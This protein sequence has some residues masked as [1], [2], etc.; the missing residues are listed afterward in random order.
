M[1]SSSHHH[2]FERFYEGKNVSNV[3]LLQFVWTD[4]RAVKGVR[5]VVHLEVDL[6]EA[7][8]GKVQRSL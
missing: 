5:Q 6:G 4:G 1:V 7:V 2:D 3:Y 8:P